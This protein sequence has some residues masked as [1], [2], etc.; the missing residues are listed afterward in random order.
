M[1]IR[2]R[3]RDKRSDRLQPIECKEVITHSVRI[4]AVS[5]ADDFLT[6]IGEFIAK[7][8]TTNLRDA[9][10]AIRKDLW[11]G[12]DEAIHGQL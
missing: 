5:S 7:P 11:G 6:A 8:T 12:E 10:M 1:P 4:P 2:I 9:A 3:Y